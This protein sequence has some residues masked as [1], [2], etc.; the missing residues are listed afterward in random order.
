MAQTS[1]I[2]GLG[3]LALVAGCTPQRKVDATARP[4]DDRAAQGR[5]PTTAAVAAVDPK[6]SLTLDQ[7]RP[8]ST[9]PA[10]PSTS[11]SQQVQR[12]PI[13]ALVLFARARTAMEDNQPFT[14]V[15]LLEKAIELD[16]HSPDLHRMLGAAYQGNSAFD[17]KSIH[18]YEAAV[19]LD[20]GDFD[21]R[22]SLG[23]QYL[24]KED[25]DLAIMHLRNAMQTSDYAYDDDAAA[26][27]DY[28]LARALKQGG[29]DRA[30]LDRYE[31]LL[32]RLRSRSLSLRRN[33]ELNGLITRPEVVLLEIGQLH[34]KAERYDL[35]MEAYR[36]AAE[37][38]PENFEL[39]ARLVRL[40][41]RSGQS[42]AAASAAAGLVA[43]FRASRDSLSL[44]Q[45]IA[46][47]R[48]GGVVAYLSRLHESRPKDRSITFAL[49]DAY[50]AAGQNDRAMSLLMSEW[51]RETDD[52]QVTQRLLDIY[53]GEGN[54]LAAANLLI[55]S[56]ANQPEAVRELTPMWADLMR[57]NRPNRLR[58]NT[59]QAMELPPE[60]HAARLYWV[61]VSAERWGRNALVRSALQEAVRP[62]PPLA[63]AFRSLVTNLWATPDWS[64]QQKI[65]AVEELAN[66]A[67]R[68]GNAALAAEV[69][70][71]SLI[72]QK[73]YDAAAEAIDHAI[74]LGAKGP[75]VLVAR[76]LAAQG[77]GD[78]G[79]FEQTLWK[80]ISDRPTYED[81]YSVLFRHHRDR[82]SANKALKVLGT[83]L[84][85][86]PSSVNAR[87]LQAALQ[88]QL[89][90]PELAE[91]N[92]LKLFDEHPDDADV[93]RTL[94][95]FYRGQNG[96]Q[97]LID[98]LE[99]R[100]AER[101]D[102]R[103]LVE[104]L[105]EIYSALDRNPD[106]IRVLDEARKAVGSDP[107]LLY[108]VSSMYHQVGQQEL[109]EQLLQEVVN[110]DPTHP[111]ASNDL[112]Y[113]WADAGRHLDRAEEL[114]R[115]AVDAE[116]DNQSFLDSLGWVLYKRGKFAESRVWFEKAIGPAAFPDPIVLDHL[117]DVMY[118]LNDHENAKKQW[119]RTLERLDQESSERQDLKEL[120]L[121]VR[122][123]LKQLETGKPADV[124]PIV[125]MP[126]TE[127]QANR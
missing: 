72:Y 62:T 27:V 122:Q 79:R 86:D 16:P 108:Y 29:Y 109:S 17:A 125:E 24:A 2:V 67:E 40:M 78:E 51:E 12:P 118:R 58:I 71:L 1:R 9:P 70:G 115:I 87:L 82:G 74:K 60:A 10:P 73:K 105:V 90:Q 35:A 47:S 39:Q 42:D 20:P 127:Q 32:R 11:P 120:R 14:A 34:E 37:R 31:S 96:V 121:K 38:A 26:S 36:P 114:I 123:K 107:D 13:E 25:V 45:E 95:S 94:L 59:I 64:D 89:G 41:E 76:A 44:L 49:A 110:L 18:A 98:M 100:R 66:S 7:I 104:Y 111:S 106:A 4:L 81:A 92:L 85:N 61:S 30:A 93:I 99:K 113:Y 56:L 21:T 124:A 8:V 46:A 116:P 65:D 6:A 23:R 80:I 53:L 126:T 19:R 57:P 91:R 69:R 28:F 52:V 83:W 68:G 15:G 102:E 63:P 119:Q 88:A 97:K 77:S 101:P 75:N 22:L 50:R 117:G 5:P 48:P 55:R 3:L 54:L 112:G 33:P 43:R 84:Q 103:A